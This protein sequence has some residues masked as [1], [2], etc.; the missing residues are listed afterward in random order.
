MTE[1]IANDTVRFIIEHCGNDNISIRWFGGEPTVATHRIDQ[2]CSGLHNNNVTYSSTMTTNGYLFDEEM[3]LKAK[4]LWNLKFV[5]ICLDGTEKNYNEI[6]A[7][8]N[9]RDNPYR[10][11]LRNVGLLLD[12]GIKV[13]LR[14]N[15][16]LGNYLDFRDILTEAQ[17]RFQG[18]KLLQVYAFP[19]AGTYPDRYG[20]TLHGSDEW[21]EEKIPELN[22]I[23]REMGMFRRAVDLPSLFFTSC[24]AGNASS[25]VIGPNG[26]LARCTRIFDRKDQIVGNVSEKFDVTSYTSY[27]ETWREFCDPPRCRECVFFPNCV[28]IEKC[29][30]KDRC[31]KKETGRQSEETIKR[32]FDKWVQSKLKGDCE[33]V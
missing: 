25:M 15:F 2:I 10:R 5:M 32:V 9:V 12:Q 29:P 11:V 19:I 26:E 13:S 6:K 27:Y 4:R 31:F 24:N 16:D 17:S 23:A 21:F 30:G 3:V 22:D 18:N 33:H 14:M 20:K 8:L 28:L 1:K 7:Y